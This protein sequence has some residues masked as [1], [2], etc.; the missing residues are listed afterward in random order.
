MSRH[1]KHMAITCIIVL[2]GVCT[3]FLSGCSNETST[4]SFSGP[5]IDTSALSQEVHT[6]SLQMLLDNEDLY[7]AY[8]TPAEWQAY[9]EDYQGSYG[10]IG[11]YMTSTEEQD[12]AMVYAV[13]PDQP[14]F[15]AGL[16]PGDLIIRVDGQDVKGQTLDE[17]SLL[18]KGDAGTDVTLTL[19]H[20]DGTEEDVVVTRKVIE[21]QSVDGMLLPNHPNLAYIIIYDFAE[22][23][24][25]MF[26]EVYNR[27]A[28]ESVQRNDGQPF[29]GIILDLR[30]NGG[31]SFYAAL[32]IAGLFV[33]QGEVLVWQEMQDGMLKQT[34]VD[35][36]LTGVPLVCLQNEW[37]ASASEV[38]LGALK[39]H[40]AAE[41]VGTVTYGKGITQ[42]SYA[43]P[44]GSAVT[45]T[46]SKYLTPDQNDIHEIGIEPD[47]TVELPETM[48]I[49][50]IYDVD[51]ENDTQLAAAIQEMLNLLAVREPAA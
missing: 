25:D 30:N 43:L 9:V 16:Q 29:D 42:M 7:A 46:D 33:P 22:N 51:E 14:A 2:I 39:D 31:G 41:L 45:F 10:G 17:V 49:L 23:T 28:Q 6:A 26:A 50:D 37:T 27:L 5:S 13:M 38:L 21:S 3:L 18:V 4:T 47:V 44:S 48:S 32:D 24:P 8:Y 36:Q 34:S 35:G 12:Y 19:R 11:V 20:E 1:S 15:E 40:D